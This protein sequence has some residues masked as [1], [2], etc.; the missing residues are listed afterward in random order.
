MARGDMK[1]TKETMKE[2]T[3]LVIKNDKELSPDRNKTF[4]R[5]VEV[6][7]DGTRHYSKVLEAVKD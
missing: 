7:K 1:L 4:V 3:Y 5:I 6:D 2:M